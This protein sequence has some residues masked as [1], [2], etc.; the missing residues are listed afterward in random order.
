MILRV[1]SVFYLLFYLVYTFSPKSIALNGMWE[2]VDVVFMLTAL[3]GMLSYAFEF[4]VLNRRFWDYFFYLFIIY[5]LS[6]MAWLQMPLLKKLD[7]ADKAGLTNSVNILM[8]APVAWALFSLVKRWNA[9]NR[10]VADKGRTT[11]PAQK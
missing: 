2:W 6:Y 8:M 1:Y 10:S 7:L 9:P 5:E 3:C 4:R 11:P